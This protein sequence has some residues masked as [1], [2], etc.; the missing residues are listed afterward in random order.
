MSN[1]VTRYYAVSSEPNDGDQHLG[2]AEGDGHVEV[3]GLFDALESEISDDLMD[4]EKYRYNVY[5][6]TCLGEFETTC[7]RGATTVVVK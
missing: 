1:L 6:V 2:L 5:S 4:G 7:V 3:A